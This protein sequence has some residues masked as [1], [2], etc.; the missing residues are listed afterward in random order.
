ML[1]AIYDFYKSD[2]RP[3]H[4]IAFRRSKKNHYP[5]NVNLAL[6]LRYFARSA[7]SN[8]L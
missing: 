8:C 7:K 3:N 4:Q 1:Y 2:Y 5:E 6:F